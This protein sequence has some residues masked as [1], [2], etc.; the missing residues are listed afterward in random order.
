MQRAFIILTIL[1][2][3]ASPEVFAQLSPGELTQSH[4]DLEGIRNCTKCHVLG[5]KVSNDKCLE[6]HKDLRARIQ[7][8]KGYHASREVKGKDCASCHS[9]HHGRQFEMIRFDQK[10]FDH[11]LTGY[12]LTG[13]HKKIDCRDCH[14]PDLISDREIRSRKKTFLGLSQDCAACHEDAHQ[15][16]LGTDCAACHT[17]DAF[18]PAVK[19]DHNKTAFALIG[20]H[21]QVDCAS[22][23]QEVTRDGK[24]FRQYADVPFSECSSCHDDPHQNH[25]LNHCSECHT[26]QGF[27]EFRGRVRFNHNRTDFPLKG[28]HQQTDCASCHT[29]DAAPRVL[30]QDRTGIQ[31]SDCIQC[32]EDTHDGRFGNAC[33]NCHQEESFTSI[34][35]LDQFDHS[36]TEFA[37]LGKH[38]QVDC[39]DCHTE[40]FLDPLPHNT[41]ASCH[42]DYHEG[43]FAREGTVRDCADCHTVDGFQG[44]LFTMEDHAQT[45]FPLDGAHLA[46][47]CFACHLKEE[48]WVFRDL[49]KEC[50]A[51]HADV[52][53]GQIPEK[54][55]PDHRCDVCHLTSRWRD[56]RFDHDQTPFQLLGIHVQQECRACHIPETGYPYG[57]F[58]GLASSCTGCHENVH[59][60]QF[61][62][63]G[64][65]DCKRC[66]GFD[67]WTADFFDHDRTAFP[68]E[69]RHAEIACDECHLPETE[70]GVT[71]VRYKIE[72]FACIDCH[73]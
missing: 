11:R 66:H 40:S 33:A 12:E 20:K 60:T 45:A 5:N 17:T 22:C 28:K 31:T 48:K 24:T 6:C 65:T 63:D 25:L 4:A 36:L 61:D 15:R 27:D 18:A 16:T 39:R 1:F 9:E 30:F 42:A 46:T 23:H 59:G 71:F 51:C 10:T 32:H 13:S 68:L 47:P 43:Q 14:K 3:L 44:S 26:E 70:N 73:K 2:L 38:Q 57:K 19:F 58:V 52:H 35:N 56:S 49:G 21:R 50:T 29:L 54:Y 34:K 41:C 67:G 69:G 8:R 7:A 64:S 37:L 55:D 62:E 72:K 53:D